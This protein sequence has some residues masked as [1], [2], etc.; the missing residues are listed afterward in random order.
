MSEGDEE[1][2]DEPE[3]SST[4][5]DDDEV[6]SLLRTAMRVDRDAPPN[7]LPAVQRKIRQRS[8]GK[9]YS[10]GWSTGG[11]PRSSY[12]I[13]SVVMLLV[14]FAMYLALSPGSWGTP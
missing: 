3:S 2:L 8:Q 14:L 4:D 9:F 11:S 5:L 7:V 6:R 10:D 1:R 12:F 13:T